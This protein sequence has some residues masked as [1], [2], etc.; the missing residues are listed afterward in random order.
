[1]KKLAKTALITAG[2]FFLIGAIILIICSFFAWNRRYI[3]ADAI[4]Q[5]VHGI[6]NHNIYSFF[7]EDWES[8]LDYRFPIQ[9][10][11]YTDDHTAKATDITQLCIN[12]NYTNFK[13]VSSQDDVFHISYEGKGKCQYY[14][15]DSVFYVTGSLDRRTVNTN[16]LTL[17][18]P[19][20]AFSDV[21]IDFGA[22][23][24][25]LSSLKCDT[26]N[27]NVGAGELTLDGT[28]CNDISADCGAGAILIKDGKTQN[29]DFEVGM[30]ELVYEG[31]INDALCAEVGM[32]NITLQIRDTQED[33]NYDLECGMGN[34]TLGE[35]TYRGFAV[36][37]EINNNANSDYT[38]QCS[39]GN[40][41]VS[42]EDTD[43]N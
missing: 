9:S 21:S 16:L 34:I 20:T 17:S 22:G 7:E 1:M 11:Q 23:T 35:K 10:G 15:E 6:F 25:N 30:G 12:L 32:G 4:S 26:L 36:E 40:I 14:T 29:A 41:D 3:L 31:F 43:K 18:V 42:F 33:H 13:L 38:L 39:M 5:E 27:I 37:K 8:N 2:I 28:D 24:A 19:N